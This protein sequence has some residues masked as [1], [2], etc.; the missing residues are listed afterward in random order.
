MKRMGIPQNSMRA[1][2]GSRHGQIEKAIDKEDSERADRQL[3]RAVVRV[4]S[5]RA[6][7]LGTKE[8]LQKRG[9]FL[10]DSLATRRTL[11]G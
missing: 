6:L 3:N 7:V 11:F 10:L 5:T 8:P 9:F 4:T 2:S 1:A